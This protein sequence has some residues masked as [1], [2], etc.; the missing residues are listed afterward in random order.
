VYCYPTSVRGREAGAT[1][2]SLAPLQSRFGVTRLTNTTLLDCIGM[3]V[4]AA[5]RPG[6]RKGS[7]C[8][9][10]GKAFDPL[11]ARLGALCEAYELAA[12]EFDPAC[13][14][15][16]R[17]SLEAFESQFEFDVYDFGVLARCLKNIDRAGTE[18]D[19]VLV[20]EH[21]A[22]QE[23][24]LPAGLVFAPYA[25][26][27]R[28]FSQ[29]SNGLSGG[30]THAEA[31]LHALC[32]LIERDTLSFARALPT[33]QR[34]AEIKSDA[35]LE[36]ECR[37]SHAGLRLHTTYCP[38]EFDLPMFISYLFD[39]GLV[40][41]VSVA[42]GQGLHLDREVALLRAATEAVQSRLTNIH[43][44]RDDIVR[45]YLTYQSLGAGREAEDFLRLERRLTQEIPQVRYADVPSHVLAGTM[46]GSLATVADMLRRRGFGA[47]FTYELFRLESFCILKVIVPGLEF[48]SPDF[49]RVGKRLLRAVGR[50]KAPLERQA[51]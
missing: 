3:P 10:S 34:V 1:Y 9:S 38:N 42:R 49:P 22:A 43:G 26:R 12:V 4:Y 32:E 7:L 46:E 2:E 44:G 30:S 29:T 25:E 16:R 40:D 35:Y 37:V 51:G 48:Y 28:L 36:L 15:V 47:I 13:D 5:I 18:L 19:L 6:A 20:R 17:T 39:P 33:E 41:T 31:L 14:R 21:F 24:W 50:R 8:V 45:R 23:A 11:Q 27:P